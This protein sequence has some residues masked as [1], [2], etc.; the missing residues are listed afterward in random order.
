MDATKTI[1]IG[2]D[3]ATDPRKFGYGSDG[4][5]GEG[6]MRCSLVPCV[7]QKASSACSAK[8]LCLSDWFVKARRYVEAAGGPWFILSA[9]FGLVHP[10]AVIARYERT[11]NTMGVG[12]RRAWA[13]RVISQMERDLPASDEIVV[14]AYTRYI[15]NPRATPC[16]CSFR[17]FGAQTACSR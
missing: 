2:L 3:V 13:R 10:D 6:V 11:L 14:P 4:K 9:E 16:P 5:T 17:S 7:G 8:N 15:V 12:A 1:L